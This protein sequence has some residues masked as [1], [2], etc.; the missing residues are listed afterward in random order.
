MIKKLSIK[1]FKSFGQ[2]QDI[3]FAPITLF[4]GRNNSGKS[5]VFDLLTLLSQNQNLKYLSVDNNT[6]GSGLNLV[7]GYDKLNEIGFEINFCDEYFMYKALRPDHSIFEEMNSR[8]DYSINEFPDEI[9]NPDYDMYDT[10]FFKPIKNLSFGI[11]YKFFGRN[12]G[13]F[14]TNYFYKNELHK[15]KD[16]FNLKALASKKNK[17]PTLPIFFQINN[18]QDREINDISKLIDDNN[19]LILKKINLNKKILDSYLSE[20]N[21]LK[22]NCRIIKNYQSIFKSLKK[23][24]KEVIDLYRIFSS[25]L[26]RLI[27]INKSLGY[28]KGSGKIN[29][30]TDKLFLDLYQ[31]DSTEEPET[32]NFKEIYPNKQILDSAVRSRNN[33][34]ELMIELYDNLYPIF[35]KSWI[36]KNFKKQP[37]G[38]DYDEAIDK[39]KSFLSKIPTNKKNDLGKIIKNNFDLNYYK[40]KDHSNKFIKFLKIYLFNIGDSEYGDENYDLNSE[41]NLIIQNLNKEDEG[42]IWT[43]I[44]AVMIYLHAIKQLI[45]IAEKFSD[46]VTNVYKS[47]YSESDNE[48]LISRIIDRPEELSNSIDKNNMYHFIFKFLDVP[49]VLID[50]SRIDFK[51]YVNDFLTKPINNLYKNLDK[52]EEYIKKKETK[53]YFNFL[54][55]NSVSM[56]YTKTYGKYVTE[57]WIKKYTQNKLNFTHTSLD[58]LTN[59][60]I[61]N[62]FSNF[63]YFSKYVL[64]QF[65]KEKYTR[66][67]DVFKTWISKTNLIDRNELINSVVSTSL[68]E[69]FKNFQ[70][71]NIDINA[72]KRS[73]ISGD[74]SLFDHKDFSDLNLNLQKFGITETLVKK[75]FSHLNEDH[76]SVYLKNAKGHLTNIY[77]IGVGLKKILIL[78]TCLD[79]KEKIIYLEEPETNIHPE[80]QKGIGS[81]IVDS[82]KKGNNQILVE[83]HSEQL[84][85]R[86]LREV[87]EGKLSCNDLSVN[88]ISNIKGETIVKNI[89]VDERGRFLDVWPQGFFNERLSEF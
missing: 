1:N 3:T 58:S 83:T 77:D 72:I 70:K 55:K 45:L 14:A 82:W 51:H 21:W 2:E 59:E 20:I 40:S 65:L 33:T 43:Q 19:E 75:E 62:N 46:I 74:S 67:E 42:V 68:P 39:F 49:N 47:S 34:G 50:F 61:K 73:F 57:D 16:Y 38:K 36:L 86:L 64:E 81:T 23:Q 30:I 18:F 71:T 25:S 9:E 54:L 80:F 52:A 89:R 5:T 79:F 41:K 60:N 48:F 32:I 37:S 56:D 76:F 4:Y 13:M 35:E 78:L 8:G 10:T 24:K 69:L 11:S 6:I 53:R 27:S 63:Y 85:L 12:F 15:D 31:G 84:I 17:K 26:V 22:K 88:Y 28:T 66:R 7:H 29:E 87:R 44:A